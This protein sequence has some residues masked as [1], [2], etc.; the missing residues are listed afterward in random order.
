M[1]SLG[2]RVA[3]LESNTLPDGFIPEWAKQCAEAEA[4]LEIWITEDQIPARAEEIAR[5]F[6]DKRAYDAY[7]CGR[8][9]NALAE[10][11]G[12]DRKGVAA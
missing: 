3:K 12:L 1:G 2:K 11:D 8:F 5:Q 9:E 10:L 7:S 6:R 4:F